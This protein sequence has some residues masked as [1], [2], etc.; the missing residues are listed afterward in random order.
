MVAMTSSL[1]EHTAVAGTRTRTRYIKRVLAAI[2]L[3]NVAVSLAKFFYGVVTNSSSM[4]ADGIHSLFDAAGSAI[5][6]VGTVLASRP[7]DSDHPYGHAKFETFA[8]VI[9]GIL[10]LAAA[11]KVGYD[12]V[13]AL[14]AQHSEVRV[15]P[16]SFI[17]MLGTLCVNVG[18]TLYERRAGRLVASEILAADAAHTLSD[19]FVTVGVIVG[20]ALVWLGLPLADS[21]TALVVSAIILYT[22]FTVFRQALTTFS[23]KARIPA[24]DIAK[25]VCEHSGVDQCHC[26][27]TRG[28]PS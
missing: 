3:L 9:L 16:L 26:I 19:V 14:L 13:T 5:G 8:S 23:D 6:F 4:Q 7:A 27:R 15:T 11:Y 28:V 10:L 24:D 20:L 22:A 21:V 12:A 1:T 2:F 17:I 25:L 18:V